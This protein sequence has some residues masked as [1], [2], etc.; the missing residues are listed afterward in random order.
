M[1]IDRV[2]PISSYWR[3]PTSSTSS[4][5]CERE[6]QAQ[7]DGL[8]AN[9]EPN[10]ISRIF[11]S[12]V[13]GGEA[14]SDLDL[15]QRNTVADLAKLVQGQSESLSPDERTPVRMNMEDPLNEENLSIYLGSRQSHRLRFLQQSLP[16]IAVDTL[17]RIFPLFD[18][19][20]LDLLVSW[21][22]PPTGQRGH[23]ILHSLRLGPEFSIVEGVR[24][25]VDTA[26]AA[27][28]K[29]TRTMYEETGRLRRVLM[30]SV[31]DGVLAKEEDPIVARIS[32]GKRRRKGAVELDFTK[33]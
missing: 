6:G 8:I 19:L 25:D 26:I 15:L 20:D 22:I 17:L 7:P 21:S 1:S 5:S 18:P 16:T 4:T 10:Q 23:A 3:T 11:L 32:T 27:G 28:G 14:S 2:Q 13:G 12:V 9:L 24:R 30:D 29:Q 31:L 33:G